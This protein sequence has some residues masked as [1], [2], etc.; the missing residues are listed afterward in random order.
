MWKILRINFNAN[1]RTS[2]NDTNYGQNLSTHVK[3]Q[4]S[5]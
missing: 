3:G 5:G 4:D 1:I 2:S